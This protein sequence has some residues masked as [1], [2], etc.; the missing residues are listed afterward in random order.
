LYYRLFSLP[1][2]EIEILVGE[3]LS[4]ILPREGSILEIGSRSGEHGVVL[5]KHFPEITLQS[6][7]P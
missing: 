3:L 5:Q 7:Y 1:L 6:S 2:R 4:R